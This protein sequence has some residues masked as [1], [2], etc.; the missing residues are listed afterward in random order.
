M[1]DVN[2]SVEISYR[3]DLKQLI[4]QLKK[5]PGITDAEAKKMVSQ[6]DRQFKR[7]ERSAKKASAKQA[8]AMKGVSSSANK[9]SLSV[10]NLGNQTKGLNK[11]FAGAGQAATM[12]SPELGEMLSIGAGLTGAFESL[13]KGLK[14]LNPAWLVL[15]AV[16]G[17]A[18]V[19]YGVLNDENEKHLDL[20]TRTKEAEEA[21]RQRM[22]GLA[23]TV[24][25]VS[26]RYRKAATALAIFTGQTT[27]M[28]AEILAKKTEINRATQ[29]DVDAMSE[30]IRKNEQLVEIL[31]REATAFG[32][33]TDEEKELVK[34]AQMRFETVNKTVDIS[35]ALIDGGKAARA[36][37]VLEKELSKE[38]D[39]QKNIR[40]AIVIRGEQTVEMTEELIRLQ[41]EY[42][43]AQKEEEARLKRIK[44]FKDDLKALQ[45]AINAALEQ[46]LDPIEKIEL[47]YQKQIDFLESQAHL[48]RR[49]QKLRLQHQE[50]ITTLENK[51]AAEMAAAIINQDSAEEKAFAREQERLKKVAELRDKID[52]LQL[53]SSEQA[54]SK[55][56]QKYDTEL[57]MIRQVGLATGEHHLIVLA[58]AELQKDLDDEIHKAKMDNIK[59]EFKAGLSMAMDLSSSI[60]E[61]MD[62]EASKLEENQKKDIEAIEARYEAQNILIDKQLEKEI[63]TAEQAKKM[64]V[65]L[66]NDEFQEI[67]E[68][69]IANQAKIDKLRNQE[70]RLNQTASIAN[71][72]FRTAEAVMASLAT[73]PGPAGAILAAGAGATGAAQ[74][75][76]VLNQEPPSSHMG[77][78][79]APDEQVRTVLTGEAV[80]DRATVNRIGGES[81]VRSLMNDGSSNDSVV[82]LQPFRHIDRYNKSARMMTGRRASRRY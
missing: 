59:K 12:L 10:Q 52:F 48:I 41:N 71:I 18:A 34:A 35:A 33:M 16:V 73:Y 75:A 11:A 57:D 22:A 25:S 43:E 37:N 53:S 15:G 74:A 1:A 30:R 5:M 49:N 45:K 72:A 67:N 13:T 3:A 38:I 77:G 4:G 82:V 47:S 2:K 64:R 29:N 79:L 42:N 28:D 70:F 14:N 24:E 50:A 26:D 54:H 6:L 51:Q 62:Q 27:E 65:N 56:I 66:K 19:A 60:S 21:E 40:D 69:D 78:F 23:S 44:K 46:G 76:V 9:A 68:L 81:G 61:L 63:I 7:A 32:M 80:L 55:M 20:L 58:Q 8:K 36:R 31:N 39:E 17:A